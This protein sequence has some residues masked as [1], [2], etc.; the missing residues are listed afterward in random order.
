MIIN[1][2]EIF[3]PLF[4]FVFI[5]VGMFSPQWQ[6]LTSGKLLLARIWLVSL[7]ESSGTLIVTAF[8][9]LVYS[10]QTYNRS[11]CLCVL[12]DHFINFFKDR[13]FHWLDYLYLTLHPFAGTKVTKISKML[14]GKCGSRLRGVWYFDLPSSSGR[15]R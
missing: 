6:A 12:E 4:Y 14:F 7:L 5:S 11:D 13:C 10:S 9:Y 8:K 3:C 2:S 1:A 15:S